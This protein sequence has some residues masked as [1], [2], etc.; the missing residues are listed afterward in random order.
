[1][2]VQAV[3]DETG[4]LDLLVDVSASLSDTLAT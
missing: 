1:M 2:L 4:R 3:D